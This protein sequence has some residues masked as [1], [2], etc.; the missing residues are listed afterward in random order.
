MA[1][2]PCWVGKQ[3]LSS[4]LGHVSLCAQMYHHIMYNHRL[5]QLAALPDKPTLSEVALLNYLLPILLPYWVLFKT[6]FIDF[7][8]VF[9]FISLCMLSHQSFQNVNFMRTCILSLFIL[10]PL[11]SVGRRMEMIMIL[12][13][14]AQSLLLSF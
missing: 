11:R 3:S 12:H 2:P 4:G 8:C 7:V 13:L 9:V 1:T 14:I 10:A 6:F 5:L